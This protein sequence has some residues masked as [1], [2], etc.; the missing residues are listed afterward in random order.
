MFEIFLCLNFWNKNHN[1]LDFVLKISDIPIYIQFFESLKS[2]FIPSPSPTNIF[3]FTFL[4]QNLNQP[5]KN[6]WTDTPPTKKTPCF[7]KCANKYLLLW[8]LSMYLF[9]K[10]N[11][12][13]IALKCNFVINCSKVMNMLVHKFGAW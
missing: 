5:A 1:D 6:R 12:L 10:T 4:I 13:S 8:I 3:T 7:K 9:I 2:L 11:Y